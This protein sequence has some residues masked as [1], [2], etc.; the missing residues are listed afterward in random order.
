ME[1]ITAIFENGV[2]RPSSPLSLK[3]GTLLRLQVLSSGSDG[4]KDATQMEQ[5]RLRF[6]EQ[7]VTPAPQSK[8]IDLQQQ[9]S[10]NQTQLMSSRQEMQVTATLIAARQILDGFGTNNYETDDYHFSRRGE[11]ITVAAKDGRGIIAQR[12]EGQL[13][14]NLLVGD[15]NAIIQIPRPV[16]F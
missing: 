2:L 16:F 5:E 10:S 12:Q 15:L 4:D 7:P 11:S 3:K 6:N 8:T 14:G 1:I 9:T 13:L